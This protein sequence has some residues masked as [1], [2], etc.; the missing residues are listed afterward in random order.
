MYGDELA[1]QP[2]LLDGLEIIANNPETKTAKRH[3]LTDFAR[4]GSSVNARTATVEP[5]GVV[6]IDLP[7]DLDLI[8]RYVD[9]LHARGAKTSTIRR[10]L[11]TFAAY[12]AQHRIDRDPRD[13]V[14]VKAA[15]GRVLDAEGRGADRKL[16][17]AEAVLHRMIDAMDEDFE[18]FTGQDRRV[19]L[20]YLRDRA[21]LLTEYAGCLTRAELESLH[22]ANVV[23]GGSA[24]RLRV[25][26]SGEMTAGTERVWVNPRRTRDVEIRRADDPTYCPVVALR[27]WLKTAGIGDGYVFRGVRIAGALTVQLTGRAIQDIHTYRAGRVGLD[28]HAISSHSIRTGHLATKAH[29]GASDE[30]LCDLAGLRSLDSVA[31]VVSQSRLAARAGKRIMLV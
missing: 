31:D 28:E 22:Y 13:D 2:T 21:L 4:F 12:H 11:W 25:N 17:V 9:A 27:R 3:D 10:R 18:T 1:P 29:R 7:L 26:P 6:R 5:G 16:A 20:S 23:F 14:K 8:A 30:T 19:T 15:W 24:M